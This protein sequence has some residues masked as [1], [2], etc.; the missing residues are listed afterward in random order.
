M[1]SGPQCL[2]PPARVVL[3]A[4]PSGCGKSRLAALLGLPILALD[5]FYR[6]ASVDLPCR[7]DGSID[8][9]E[10]ATWDGGAAAEALSVLCHRGVVEVPTYS[11]ADN[12]AV[13]RHTVD[14]GA[15]SIVVAE[16][17][18]APELVG[19]LTEAG[20]L[21]DALLVRQGR[22]VTFGRRLLRDLREHRK[23][24]AQLVR[25]GWCKTM[26]EPDVVA[27]HRALGARPTTKADARRRVAALAAMVG[28]AGI[29]PATERL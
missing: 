18:F 1:A 17:I 4:G 21:A 8:W 13:G 6:A 11:F 22:W 26:A 20:L 14:R 25:S 29:E 24:P 19:P 12:R 5:D 15:A 28:P 7:A 3:L 23:R 16:G 2:P 27:R 9:E 10:P